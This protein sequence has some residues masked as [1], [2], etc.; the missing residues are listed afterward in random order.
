MN[1]MRPLSSVLA[2][3]LLAGCG[4]N[5]DL[6]VS[7]LVSGDISGLTAP[8]LVLQNNGS[9]N[10]TVAPGTTSFR[11]PQS[12]RPPAPY[13]VTVLSQPEELTCSVSNGSGT[14]GT[15]TGNVQV[16]C[17]PVSASTYTVGGAVTGL[18]AGVLILQNNG[19]DNRTVASN[20]SFQFATA[21]TE[22]MPYAVTI[23]SQP[24]G[25]TCQVSQGNGT[26]GQVNVSDVEVAC[27]PATTT[28]TASASRLVLSVNNTAMNPALTGNA[29]F[30]TI[31]NTDAVTATG[32]AMSY[33]TFPMGTTAMT[34]CA[35]TLAAGATCTVTITPGSVTTSTCDG[36]TAP[37]PDVLSVSS[38]NAPAVEVDV[39]VVA[40]GCV[41]QGG[42]LFAIDDTTLLTGNI[43]GKVAALTDQTIAIGWHN[44]SY[45]AIY[46]SGELST[47]WVPSPAVGALPGML[48]CQGNADG[49]CNTINLYTFYAQTLPDSY[50]AGQCRA[51]IEGY[52]DWYLPAICE[53]GYSGAG[54]AGCGTAG[55]PTT[56]NMNS[57]L[58]DR[59]VPGAPSGFHWSSTESSA[60]PLGHAWMHHFS[61]SSIQL[62]VDKTTPSAVRCAR[63]ITQ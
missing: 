28:L 20:G 15:F 8:G 32:L 27:S 13:N 22:G 19:T 36:G 50:A 3:L 45:D 63:V 23:L 58:V 12:A 4:D 31:Q 37:T 40:Y 61:G 49:L 7:F 10:L 33:P 57:S 44:D 21:L 59:G 5:S 47:P 55:A 62:A 14:V 24:E 9:D 35:D 39:L 56:Q 48:A 29:R 26:V 11:F 43:G 51:T 60:F 25:L 42:L 16:A 30:V 41:Y 34:T 38:D 1:P 6:E 52:S 18:T 46:G 53:M 17:E 2:F 54:A